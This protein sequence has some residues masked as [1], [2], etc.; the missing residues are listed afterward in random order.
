VGSL[1][2]GVSDLL[3][4]ATAS[5]NNGTGSLAVQLDT[6]NNSNGSSQCNVDCWAPCAVATLFI[7]GLLAA[8]V[9]EFFPHPRRLS[10]P[11]DTQM[12]GREDEDLGGGG[13]PMDTSSDFASL[14]TS[15]ATPANLSSLGT[16]TATVSSIEGSQQLSFPGELVG[17]EFQIERHNM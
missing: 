12:D 8:V 13:A 6:F 1:A 11:M 10:A 14:G 3:A 5:N 15:R 16:S 9:A 17:G 2:K 4:A 7:L